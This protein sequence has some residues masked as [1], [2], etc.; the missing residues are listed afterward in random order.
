MLSSHITSEKC[1]WNL[2]FPSFEAAKNY[3]GRYNDDCETN[4]FSVSERNAKFFDKQTVYLS[5]ARKGILKRHSSLTTVLSNSRRENIAI[6]E[7]GG[8]SGWLF[9]FLDRSSIK[10]LREY[11]IIETQEVIRYFHNEWEENSIVKFVDIDSLSR[12]FQ[13]E[14]VLYSNSVLQYF[15]DNSLLKKMISSIEP[16]LIILDDLLVGLTGEE[17]TMQNYYGFMIANR[18]LDEE[19]MVSEIEAIGYSLQE[20]GDYVS[21]ISTN[22]HQGIWIRDSEILK[23]PVHRSLIFSRAS[24]SITPRTKYLSH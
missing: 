19:K 13:E 14:V 16:D 2:L 17:Y 21:N 20:S 6:V 8:G 10:S 22:M 7:F 24:G 11:I 5:E 12:V 1:V 4:F 23:G 18:F 3:A 15:E 9:A